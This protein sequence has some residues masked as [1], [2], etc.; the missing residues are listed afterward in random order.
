MR[1]QSLFAPLSCSALISAG[2]G[3]MMPVLPALAVNSE[4]NNIN[5]VEHS[6]LTNSE[7]FLISQGGC[8]RATVIE[9]YETDTYYASIC[10]DGNGE[11]FYYGQHKGNGSSVNVYGVTFTDSGYYMA[12]TTDDSGNEYMYM[13]GPSLD[14]YENGNLIFS[15]PTY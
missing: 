12:T 10:A 3:L 2:L 7:Q 6:S 14:V 9:A 13:V 5:P 8:P 11:L 1:T 4:V 15:E